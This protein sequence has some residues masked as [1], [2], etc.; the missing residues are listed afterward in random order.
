M[1]PSNVIFRSTVWFAPTGAD[2]P[3][4]EDCAGYLVAALRARGARVDHAPTAGKGGW[5]FVVVLEGASCHVFVQR[6]ALRSIEGV[7]W[8][9]QVER[10]LGLWRR[11]LGLR[12]TPEDVQ[13]LCREL[14]AILRD[15][16]VFQS[17]EWMDDATFK[18]LR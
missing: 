9:I 1:L 13:P 4:G 18:L 15:G 10:Q 14:S 5:G 2:E 6:T 12:G 8:V 16:D 7:L 17:V 3:Y 11:L